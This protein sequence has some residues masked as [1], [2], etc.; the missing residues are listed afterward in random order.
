M[1]SDLEGVQSRIPAEQR[2]NIFA[3]VIYIPDPLGLFLDNLRRELVPNCQPHAHVSVL[4]PRPLAVEWQTASRQAEELTGTW[5]PFEIHLTN[6][7]VFP[8]TGVIYIE[9]GEGGDELRRMH[10]AMNGTAL[11]FEEPF[12]YHPHI[13]VAQELPIGQVARVREE[14]TARWRDYP[15]KHSFRADCVVLVQNTLSD[16][17]IDLAEYPLGSRLAG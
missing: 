15:G 4:P 13:T 10:A 11:G 6:V 14:A 7:A 3:L 5:P 16:C 8:V 2:L 17:W 1:A 9:V 12:A